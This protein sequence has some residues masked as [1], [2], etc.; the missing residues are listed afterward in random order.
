MAKAAAG[1]GT[2]SDALSAAQSSA[3]KSMKA[4]AIPADAGK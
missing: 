2:L 1:D 3:L 4:Q